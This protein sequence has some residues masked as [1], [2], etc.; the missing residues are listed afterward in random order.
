MLLKPIHHPSPEQLSPKHV[1]QHQS[2]HKES[3]SKG[4]SDEGGRDIAA[5]ADALASKY[6]ASA[7][8]LSSSSGAQTSDSVSD[9]KL[10]GPDF[11]TQGHQSAVRERGGRA[12]ASSKLPTG[13]V[14]VAVPGEHSRKPQLAH[15]LQPYLP[16]RPKC[17]EVVETHTARLLFK[18]S[19]M[20]CDTNK[21]GLLSQ[22]IKL[23]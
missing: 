19:R 13:L 16:P 20:V 22:I 23:F 5:S 6:Q 4:M 12:F 7:P 15:L 18:T 1:V 3:V 10:Q 9:C 11:R 21:L 14:M 2:L 17:L 8:I